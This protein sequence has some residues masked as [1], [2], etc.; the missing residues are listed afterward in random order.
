MLQV[1]AGATPVAQVGQPTRPTRV[2]PPPPEMN[3]FRIIT[4]EPEFPISGIGRRAER[5]KVVTSAGTL[6]VD[7]SDDRFALDVP[8]EPNRTNPIFLHS[9]DKRGA[10]SAPTVIEIIRDNTAP[11]LFVDSH[12][13]GEEVTSESIVLFGRVGDVLGGFLGLEVTVNGTCADVDIGIGNNGTFVS[14]E[15]MLLL[16]VPTEIP[17]LVLD[18]VFN[19]YVQ[20]LTITRRTPSGPQLVASGGEG[21]E[22]PI[23]ALLSAP[24]EVTVFDDDGSVFVHKLVV[25]EIVRSNGLLGLDALT[26]D[27][28]LLQL[29]TNSEGK[30][31]VHYRLGYDA[32]CA[33]NRVAVRS[34]GAENELLFMASAQH[35]AP[36]QINLGSGNSQRVET[37]AVAPLRV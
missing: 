37:G 30:A 31:R 2:V 5:V 16:D 13:D 8:L 35:G 33:N 28:R 36:N 14:N 7:V 1:I 34:A 20:T 24:L 22:G 3:Y 11:W 10:Q 19:E 15:V 23:G 27:A 6:E 18:K 29:R 26:Q 9:I 12:V 17:V 4:A 21:Q 32:G 25:F